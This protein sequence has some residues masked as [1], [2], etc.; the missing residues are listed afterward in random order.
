MFTFTGSHS[1]VTTIPADSLS[2][3]R[4]DAFYCGTRFGNTIDSNTLIADPAYFSVDS[5]TGY[6]S[7]DSVTIPIVAADYTLVGEHLVSL[8]WT[9]TGTDVLRSTMFKITFTCDNTVTPSAIIATTAP[10]LTFTH[11]TLSPSP[12]TVQM[13]TWALDVGSPCFTYSN[14]IVS[15]AD[16]TVDLSGHF[17]AF[18][19]VNFMLPLVGNVGLAGQTISYKLQI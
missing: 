10:T 18:D 1:L 14:F 16:D 3:S 11:D 17:A 5:G 13:S 19:E 7:G 15:D 12:T 6:N 4:G 2:T 8:K 9:I